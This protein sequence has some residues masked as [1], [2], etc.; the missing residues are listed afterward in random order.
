MG[1]AFWMYA[2]AKDDLALCLPAAP[3]EL[4]NILEQ[5]TAL[6]S[7]Y[8]LV[9]RTDKQP[10]LAHTQQTHPQMTMQ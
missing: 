6:I 10:I 4:L 5:D 9:E 3:H 1:S 7:S 2:T 8:G